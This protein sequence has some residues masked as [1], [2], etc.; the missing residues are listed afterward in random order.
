MFDKHYSG[1]GQASSEL[2]Y[3]FDLFIRIYQYKLWK[4]DVILNSPDVLIAIIF[5]YG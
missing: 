4:P 5:K 3:R 2:K 1:A